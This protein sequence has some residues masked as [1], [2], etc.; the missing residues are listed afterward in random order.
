VVDREIRALGPGEGTSVWSLGGRFTVKADSALSEG[1]LALVESLAFRSTEPPLHV[2]HREDEAWYVL[3][4]QM[5]FYVGD[6][7]EVAGPGSFVYAPMGLPHAFT[8]D[9]EPTRVLVLAT[10]AGF[11]HF[12]LE[13]GEPATGDEPPGP[14]HVPAPDVLGP[15]GARYGIEVIGPPRR[16]SHPAAE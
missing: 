16:V 14:L 12:A 10:P 7:V 15:V 2:H 13:L 11:E 8:V 5:T 1:R 6:R 4:G 9:I 3:D